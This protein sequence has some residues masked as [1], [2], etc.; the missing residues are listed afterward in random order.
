MY[1][2]FAEPKELRLIVKTTTQNYPRRWAIE[3]VYIECNNPSIG[4][5]KRAGCNVQA[6]FNAPTS[7]SS[8]SSFFSSFPP[9]LVVSAPSGCQQYYTG[10]SGS[11]STF[12]IACASTLLVA[13][14]KSRSM[15]DE[16]KEEAVKIKK[17]QKRLKKAK[18]G[19]QPMPIETNPQCLIGNLD[20]S[21][22]VRVESDMCAIQWVALIFD[23]GADGITTAQR[24]DSE[25][26]LIRKSR[27]CL[28]PFVDRLFLASLLTH[29]LSL[30]FL[31]LS[32]IRSVLR[33]QRVRLTT[34]GWLVDFQP[35]SPTV[36]RSKEP[37]PTI[38]SVDSF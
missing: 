12:N 10:M 34:S 19:T 25:L 27:R 16:E 15:K 20:Y 26:Q 32:P 37:R 5:I 23:I 24:G 21:I 17:Q 35:V 1:I 28:W 22:C 36:A 11:I 14:R 6:A 30:F 2:D 4:K 8:S 13:G 38:G 9:F 31:L 29:S 18:N 3:F 33:T 7:L